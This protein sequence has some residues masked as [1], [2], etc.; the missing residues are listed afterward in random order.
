MLESNYLPNPPIEH[1]QKN[2]AEIRADF[3][4]E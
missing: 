3:K 2:H 1:E 4:E